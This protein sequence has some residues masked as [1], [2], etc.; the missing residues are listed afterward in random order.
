MNLTIKYALFCLMACLISCT[1]FCTPSPKAFNT[2]QKLISSERVQQIVQYDPA[3]EYIYAKNNEHNQSVTIYFHGWNRDKLSS[4][5]TSLFT[6]PAI[7]FNFPDA[8]ANKAEPWKTMNL[9]QLPDI[10]PALVILHAIAAS[11]IAESINLVGHSRGGGVVVNLLAILNH[12]EKYKKIFQTIGIDES[13]RK[14]IIQMIENGVVVLD[15]PLKDIYTSIRQKVRY[16]RSHIL[17][18]AHTN[19]QN[20]MLKQYLCSAYNTI[21]NSFDHA[22]TF[23]LQY[24]VFPL[25]TNYRPWREH[26][27]ESVKMLDGLK[28]TTIVRYD[29][30]D[31]I[32]TNNDDETFYQTLKNHNPE[33]TFLITSRK[34]GHCSSYK[35]LTD[36][37]FQLINKKF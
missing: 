30:G 18:A 26:P 17:P 32:I 3:I 35:P 24:I 21:L 25:T 34:C 1:C 22:C 13:L 29:D 37:F 28:L 20:F 8:T 15:C 16:K 27:S 23:T 36:L 9:A 33:T 19:Q 5:R 10:M 11:D 6:T 7:I 2:F 12:P 4:T 14:K 31:F